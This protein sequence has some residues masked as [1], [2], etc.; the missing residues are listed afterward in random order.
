M[1]RL[2][3]AV[4]VLMVMLVEPL[5]IAACGGGSNSGLSTPD[6]IRAVVTMT[7]NPSVLE[8]TE[9]GQ[10]KTLD[11]TMTSPRPGLTGQC[12][13]R[14]ESTAGPGVAT[15]GERTAYTVEGAVEKISFPITAANWGKGSFLAWY[16]NASGCLGEGELKVPFAVW[17]NGTWKGVVSFLGA[18]LG[19]LTAY[20][21]TATIAVNAD[22]VGTL[23][24][25]DTPGFPRQYSITIPSSPSEV[26][27]TTTGTFLYTN[28]L[29]TISVPGRL[30]VVVTETQIAY[31]ETTGWGNCSNTYAGFL[32]RPSS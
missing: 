28:G 7:A 4:A 19:S 13:F 21:E 29:A 16:E 11:L 32:K 30:S 14:F 10:K 22:G 12:V 24:A 15:R 20:D 3:G 6:E 17:P 31:Q 25:T 9:I 26:S 27:F 8:F 2:C 1:K 23:T 18:C 5:F